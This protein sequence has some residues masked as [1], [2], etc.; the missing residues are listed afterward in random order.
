VKKLLPL[1]LAISPLTACT[2]TGVGVASTVPNGWHLTGAPLL[3]PAE[4]RDDGQRIFL[5]FD[6]DQELPAVFGIT[7]SGEET[8]VNGHMRGG[9]YVV[10][11]MYP[12]LVFR[13]GRDVARASRAQT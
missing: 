12:A 13:L 5:T 8:L 1:L 3:R 4:I 11:E 7:R 10:D 2:S 6:A 9:V